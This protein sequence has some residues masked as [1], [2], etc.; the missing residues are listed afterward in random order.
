MKDL[1]TVAR[2]NK[3]NRLLKKRKDRELAELFEKAPIVDVA[4]F[5]EKKNTK[6]LAKIM[7][8]LSNETKAGLFSN[9]SESKQMSIY[10]YILYKEF[11][12]IFSLLPS[13]QR[14]DFYQKLDYKEQ[15]KL[16][17]YLDKKIKTDVIMLSSY[18]PTTAGGIMNTDFATVISYMT[19]K[20][21]ID[22]LKQDM[23]SNKMFYYIYVVNEDMQMIGVL[24]LKDLILADA[25]TKITELINKEF[26]YSYVDDDRESVA[27]KI[28]KYDIIALPILNE[29]NQLVGIVSYDDAMD[30]IRDEQ[31][32]DM[33]R[34]MGIVPQ[35]QP[36]TYLEVSSLGHFKKRIIWVTSLFLISFVSGFI[37]HKYEDIITKLTILALYIPSITDTGGN[38]G[39][40]AA[41]VVIR[42]LS[43]EQITL[44]NWLSILFKEIKIA[45]L[46]SVSLFTLAFAKVIILSGGTVPIQHSI[47]KIAFVISLTISLQVIIS[48]IIGTSLPLI[49]KKLKGDPAVAASPAITT[50]VDITGII[51]Y[52]YVVNTILR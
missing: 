47:Y 15:T 33:E 40:Q 49:A 12:D 17:P 24:S 32:E 44:S 36:L 34:F 39:S 16:L 9:L 27:T 50:L 1:A 20:Q 31:T 29:D 30:I 38:A 14:A 37:M 52:F 25:N 18:E 43:L 23:P 46:I 4:E 19:A 8:F 13:D 21:A 48:A 42:A 45:L 35:E 3:W 11:A 5:L 10:N 6:I 28:Q 26:I 22:K 2:L 51:I 41:T 7:S